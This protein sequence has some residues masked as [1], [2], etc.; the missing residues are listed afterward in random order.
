MATENPAI[1]ALIKKR[2]Y[3]RAMASAVSLPYCCYRQLRS[4][5]EEGEGGGDRTGKKV[6]K[7]L[8]FPNAHVFTFVPFPSLWHKVNNPE[9]LNCINQPMDPLLIASYN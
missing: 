8:W 3:V 4:S 9:V 5:V 6:L 1:F 2:V 7:H